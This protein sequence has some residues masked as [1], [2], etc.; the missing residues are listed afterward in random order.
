MLTQIR[1]SQ[2]QT[3]QQS[4]QHPSSTSLQHPQQYQPTLEDYILK[5]LE[6]T[7]VDENAY[8]AAYGEA[9]SLSPKEL[10]YGE[11]AETFKQILEEEG[12]I[13]KERWG[14]EKYNVKSA[15]IK[16]FNKTNHYRRTRPKQIAGNCEDKYNHLTTAYLTTKEQKS[17]WSWVPPT[18][19]IAE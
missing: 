3:Q 4:P 6:S 1:N 15:L 5:Q 14:F 9:F 13:K 2:T 8:L 19:Q 16:Y 10:D 11:I 7:K 18:P 17:F 12:K